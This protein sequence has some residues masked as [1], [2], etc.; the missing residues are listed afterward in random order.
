MKKAKVSE[1]EINVFVSRRAPTCSELAF[2]SNKRI[3]AFADLSFMKM[4]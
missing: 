1:W 3:P 4:A 2:I